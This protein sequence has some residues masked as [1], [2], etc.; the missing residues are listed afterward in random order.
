MTAPGGLLLAFTSPPADDEDGFNAWY[1]DEHAPAR[2]TVP[3]ILNARR[4]KAVWTDGPRYMALYDLATPE[5]LASPEYRRLNEQR[6]EREQ[7]MLARIPLMDRRVLRTVHWADPVSEHPRLVLTVGLEPAP[8]GEADLVAWYAEEHIPMLCAVPGW[9][10]IR[11]YQQVEGSGPR[12]VAVHEIE[13]EAVFETEPYRKATS[14][15]WRER[16]IS[17]VRRRE[18]SLFQFLRAF[19]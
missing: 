12:F 15:P 9:Q 7:A 4:Y 19:P 5:I 1:D 13:S 14:T 17:G 11:L 16:V 3:G 18:R 6:S 2:L 10:R 8:G